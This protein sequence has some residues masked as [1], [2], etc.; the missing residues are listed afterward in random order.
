MKVFQILHTKF[1]GSGDDKK[2]KG[3]VV[4]LQSYKDNDVGNLCK[5]GYFYRYFRHSR[6]QWNKI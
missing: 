6:N 5:F 3:V 2:A 4:K 1:A